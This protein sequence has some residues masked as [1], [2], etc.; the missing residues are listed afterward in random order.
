MVN[1]MFTGNYDALKQ[2]NIDLNLSQ[3]RFKKEDD[4]LAINKSN[5]DVNAHIIIQ[6]KHNVFSCHTSE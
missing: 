4:V 5:D 3:F 2:R 6:L 1:K